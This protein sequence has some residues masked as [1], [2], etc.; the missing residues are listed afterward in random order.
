MLTY[1]LQWFQGLHRNLGTLR[2]GL[3]GTMGH[4]FTNMASGSL[5]SAQISSVLGFGVVYP[6][7]YRRRT[8][9]NYLLQL[10][11]IKEKLSAEQNWIIRFCFLHYVATFIGALERGFLSRLI[12]CDN[13]I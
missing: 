2:S 4:S 11:L 7:Y 10:Y 9:L 3:F 13:G 8:D 1:I 5:G 6:Q 12:Q